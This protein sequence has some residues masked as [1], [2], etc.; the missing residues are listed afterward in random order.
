[1]FFGSGRTQLGKAISAVVELAIEID[2]TSDSIRTISCSQ[3][4]S[5]LSRIKSYSALLERMRSELVFHDDVGLF[6]TGFCMENVITRLLD[7]EPKVECELRFNT[8][9]GSTPVWYSTE[10]LRVDHADSFDGHAVLIVTD[11]QHHKAVEARA[12]ELSEMAEHD[13]LTGLYNKKA[14]Q[15]IIDDYLSGEGKSGRHTMFF[16]DLDN[17][18]SVNDTLGH[19]FGDA[20]LADV[21]EKFRSTFRREDIMCRIGGDEFIILMKNTAGRSS[22]AR[23]A[24]MLLD[25]MNQA[26]QLGNDDV[27]VTMS[28]GI[29]SY[30]DCGLTYSDL[31]RSADK[32]MYTAKDNGKNQYCFC[33]DTFTGFSPA[34][35]IKDALSEGDVRH[36]YRA[37]GKLSDYIFNCLYESN[38]L[39]R[40]LPLVLQLLGTQFGLSRVAIAELRND[41]MLITRQWNASGI[42]ELSSSIDYSG[43]LR[44][45]FESSRAGKH[46]ALR[47]NSF[48]DMP[49]NVR[50][51]LIDSGVDDV[52]AF[53]HCPFLDSGEIRGYIAFFD[54]Q[55]TRAWSDEERDTLS[56]TARLLSLFVFRQKDHSALEQTY[57]ITRQLLDG[58]PVALSL[59][60]PSTCE[61][62]CISRK[63]KQDIPHTETGSVCPYAPMGSSRSCLICPTYIWKNNGGSAPVATEAYD[64]RTKE[65]LLLNAT[66]ITLED[67]RRVCLCSRLNIDPYKQRQAELEAENARL[68]SLLGAGG[69]N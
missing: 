47:Y 29:S 61:L 42:K 6:D 35:D 33:D 23:R 22:A 38:D 37:R 50:R 3:A 60:D 13:A 66:G 69:K 18:K 48:D 41:Q 5:P 24:D 63:T 17:F 31:L 36:G 30:P 51:R 43:E 58:S 54:C 55:S 11:I 46:M 32:A 14:A 27:S 45:L 59:I 12:A 68:R 8:G 9:D 16:C 19:P 25:R 1:M 57:N 21:A 52:R 67:G 15:T 62:L 7:D 65:W 26:F 56:Y 2:F 39:D 64:N 20:L 10:F 44:A 40:T 4:F 34:P 53:L 49:A 28:I